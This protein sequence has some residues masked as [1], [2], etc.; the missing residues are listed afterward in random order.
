MSKSSGVL[1]ATGYAAGASVAASLGVLVIGVCVFGFPFTQW[2]E[3][4]GGLVGVVG[5]LAGVAGAVVGL[6]MALRPE[7]R[8]AR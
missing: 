2:A 6:S 8:A 5:T 3:W 1:K 4:Q 7:R